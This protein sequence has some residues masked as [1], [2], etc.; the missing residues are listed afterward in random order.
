VASGIA[1][2]YDAFLGALA[3]HRQAECSLSD[4]WR[5]MVV[6]EAIQNGHHGSPT[7]PLH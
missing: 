6:A 4:A 3:C 7:Y 1:G 2:E 5:S